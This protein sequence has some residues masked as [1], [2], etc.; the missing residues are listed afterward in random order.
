MI[1]LLREGGKFID[2]LSVLM[3]EWRGGLSV[4]CES[5]PKASA[6]SDILYLPEVGQGNFILLREKSENFDINNISDV[7][8]NHEIVVST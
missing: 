6:R 3:N 4:F 1:F 5:M 7:C 2:N 8:G